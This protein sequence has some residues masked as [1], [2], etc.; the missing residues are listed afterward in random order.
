[1]SVDQR[2]ELRAA[3]Y[4]GD[5]RAVLAALQPVEMSRFL[6]L[7]G[8]GLLTAM[9]QQVDAAQPFVIACASGLRARGWDGDDELADELEA[10]LAGTASTALP[11]VR[12]DLDDVSELLEGG[13]GFD[14]G[15]IDLATGEV[16]Y[17]GGVDDDNEDDVDDDDEDEDEDGRWLWVNAEAFDEGYRDMRAFVADVDDPGVADRL[18]I[19]IDGKGAFRRFKDT[20]GRWPDVE[21]KWYRFSDERRRGRARAWLRDAGYRPAVLTEPRY[22]S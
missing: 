13:P 8:D 11:T 5:G 18:S 15:R 7:A 21:D 20:I 16:R 17:V 6:Q 19:A 22:Q 12:V 2:R 14:G 10:A 1:M 4:Q 9:A 3:V